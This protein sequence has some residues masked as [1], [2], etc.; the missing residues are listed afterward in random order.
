MHGEPRRHVVFHS[1]KND[2]NLKL[3]SETSPWF[4]R[5]QPRCGWSRIQ[6]HRSPFRSALCWWNWDTIRCPP[7]RSDEGTDRFCPASDFVSMPGT[8]C[9]G[10]GRPE[11]NWFMKQWNI[12]YWFIGLNVSYWHWMFTWLA[13]VNLNSSP[14]FKLLYQNVSGKV[15]GT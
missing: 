3:T 1:F 15:K 10:R 5:Q 9:E 4:C 11:T 2:R 14:R 7:R 12:D 8:P 6:R 13:D